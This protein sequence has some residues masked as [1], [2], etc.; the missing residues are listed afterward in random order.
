MNAQP[1]E[2]PRDTPRLAKQ[3]QSVLS[4]MSDGLPRTLGDL[5]RETGYPQAS[6]SARLRDLRRKEHGE[7]IVERKHVKN[8]LWTYRIAGK[9]VRD[10]TQLA[11]L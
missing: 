2:T 7:H 8:G 10:Y 4:I 1:I 11:L 3:L 9:V 5:E 6:I